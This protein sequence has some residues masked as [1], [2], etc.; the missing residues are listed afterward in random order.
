MAA[1]EPALRTNQHR[2]SIVQRGFNL[3]PS[4][5][6][7]SMWSIKEIGGARERAAFGPKLDFAKQNR[8]RHA[9]RTVAESATGSAGER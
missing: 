1:G 5:N 7:S 9:T 8:R 6:R 3:P 2:L 4:F